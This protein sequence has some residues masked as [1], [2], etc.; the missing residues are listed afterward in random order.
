MAKRIRLTGGGA[1]PDVDADLSITK[2]LN[3]TSTRSTT[4]F[5]KA[6]SFRLTVDDKDEEGVNCSD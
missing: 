6:L 5:F 4:L 2:V 1:V 3:G